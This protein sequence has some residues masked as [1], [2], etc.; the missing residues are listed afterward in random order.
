MFMRDVS[1]ERSCAVPCTVSRA[2]STAAAFQTPRAPPRAREATLPGGHTS[3]RPGRLSPEQEAVAL[4]LAKWRI[5]QRIL[6]G[7]SL[8]K[9][10]SPVL[11]CACTDTFRRQ[12]QATQRGDGRQDGVRDGRGGL[13]CLLAGQGAAAPRVHREG[14]CLGTPVSALPLQPP[15]PSPLPSPLSAL[16]LQHAPPR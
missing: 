16:P 14:D 5:L 12:R 3:W 15:L 13:H 10:G 1:A 11:P 7:I 6:P 9:S 8:A 4:L 2:R